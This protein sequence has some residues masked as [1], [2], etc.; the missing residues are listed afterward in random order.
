MSF[1]VIMALPN[2][3]FFCS[4]L[5]FIPSLFIF[6]IVLNFIHSNSLSSLLTVYFGFICLQYILWILNSSSLLSSLCG[7]LGLVWKSGII[8][9]LPNYALC[10][11][12]SRH[13]FIIMCRRIVM[14][15]FLI[16][17]ISIHVVSIHILSRYSHVIMVFSELVGALRCLFFIHNK[18]LNEISISQ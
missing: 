15:L 4:Y 10:V 14:C 18:L 5:D 7:Y 2:F 16:V 12:V 6:V 8:L 9:H 1:Q 11:K 3:L 17:T 13:S